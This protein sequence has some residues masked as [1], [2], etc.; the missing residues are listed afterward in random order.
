MTN[1]ETIESKIFKQEDASN[2]ISKWRGKNE[3]IIFT[4][5]CFDILH[6]GHL[7]NLSQ[8]ADLGTKLIVGLNTDTSVK[9]LKGEERPI[10]S[11]HSRAILL[12]GFGFVDAVIYFNDDTP[13]ELIKIIKPNI[14]VKGGD[15]KPEEV[16]G[17]D[18]VTKNGGEVAIIKLVK[19]F[20]STSI[21]KKGGLT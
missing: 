2:L 16:V 5:G 12:A 6:V 3:K 20:S 14:L 11:E 15:Y 18:I 19:G 1:I 10:N 8:A 4:N 17:H 9:R 13:Y 7:F 21:I